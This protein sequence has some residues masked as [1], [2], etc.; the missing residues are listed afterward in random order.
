VLY[1]SIA[2]RL[3]ILVKLIPYNRGL[4][5]FWT[6]SWIENEHVDNEK[7]FIDVYRAGL[8]VKTEINHHDISDDRYSVSKVSNS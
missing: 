2:R 8:F 4:D 6:S 7:F 1:E 3:G 5:V